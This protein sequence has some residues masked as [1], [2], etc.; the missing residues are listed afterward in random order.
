[1]SAPRPTVIWRFSDGKPGHV[2]QAL[3]LLQ[4]LAERGAVEVHEIAPLPWRLALGICLTRKRTPWTRLPD[5]DILLAAGHAT[6]LSAL[7][8]RRSRGGRIVVLMRPSLPLAWFDLCLIPDHDDPPQRPNVI[9]TRGVLNRIR[10]AAVKDPQL[11]LILLGGPSRHYGWDEAQVLAQIATI[12]ATDPLHWLVATSRRTPASTTEALS[13][14]APG[15]P[16]LVPW[17]DVP[18]DW[19]PEQLGKASAVWITEDS[20]SMVY[21]ALTAGAACGLLRLPQGRESRVSRGIAKLLGDG[22][23]VGNPA[24][25]ALTDRS[26]SAR[27][28]D[29][30]RRCAAWITQHW[31]NTEVAR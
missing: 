15:K 14:L 21:E 18:P 28:L 3:G 23:L 30:A 25:A 2:N 24:G 6:H 10:P 5:P 8:A 11:G 19:L 27:R 26:L 9:A 29:E 17:Q 12:V 16:A 31:L 22:L 1:M 20:V 7:A 13:G 4:A